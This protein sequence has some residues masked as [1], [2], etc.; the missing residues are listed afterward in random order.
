[1]YLWEDDMADLQEENVF[2]RTQS[3]A[4]RS[5]S[6]ELG[7]IHGWLEGLG[8]R[9]DIR[10]SFDGADRDGRVESKDYL[11]TDSVLARSSLGGSSSRL[12]I[13]PAS[14]CF[15]KGVPELGAL[16]PSSWTLFRTGGVPN[17]RGWAN[18]LKPPRKHI[19][20]HVTTML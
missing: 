13:N 5:D 1:M 20:S 11:R 6:R 2:V 18:G 4:N 7:P 16:R 3:E 19:R 12:V 10:G 15:C 14:D 17:L 8:Y 9:R